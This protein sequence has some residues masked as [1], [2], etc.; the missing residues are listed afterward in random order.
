MVQFG[1][2]RWKTKNSSQTFPSYPNASIARIFKRWTLLVVASDEGL[3]ILNGMVSPQLDHEVKIAS[4]LAAD[5]WPAY[6][7]YLAQ[8]ESRPDIR[9]TRSASIISKRLIW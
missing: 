9:L 7:A 1:F 6:Y 8:H 3:Q 5:D 4:C 2:G